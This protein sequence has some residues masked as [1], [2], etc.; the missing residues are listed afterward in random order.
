MLIR[1]AAVVVISSLLVESA[2]I[3]GK[4][5]SVVRGEP[6]ARVQVSLVETGAS[7]PVPAT[8][9]SVFEASRQVSTPSK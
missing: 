2:E 6:L 7:R 5:S 9:V 8:A 1:C 4:V 3:K